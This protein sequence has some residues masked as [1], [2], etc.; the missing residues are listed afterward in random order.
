M[1]RAR[2]CGSSC[3][4]VILVYLHP[5]HHSFFCSQKLPKNHLKSI[6]L[7]FK[8]IDVDIPKKL[9]ASDYLQPFSLQTKQQRINNHFLERYPSLTPACAGLFE[10]RGSGLELIK[11]TFNA[12]NYIRRFSWSGLSPAISV[13]FALEMRVA[14]RNCE[15]FTKPPIL[16]A[17]GH[18][19]SSMLTFL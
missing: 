14:A 11:S 19:R 3:S 18:S 9:V 2:A 13:Q 17:Q 5:F 12:K 8:V 6:F 7:G 16:G 10:S 1:R 15:K 4:Q